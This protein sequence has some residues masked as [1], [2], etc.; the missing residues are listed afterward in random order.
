MCVFIPNPV[1]TTFNTKENVY[2][3]VV[4]TFISIFDNAVSFDNLHYWEWADLL[5]GSQ[6]PQ[7]S[8]V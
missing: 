5:L 3:A 6:P 8:T 2:T 7:I 4:F 1:K